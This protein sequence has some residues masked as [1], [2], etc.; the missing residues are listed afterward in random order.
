M[1]ANYKVDD[2]FGQIFHR[3]NIILLFNYKA[4][5]EVLIVAGFNVNDGYGKKNLVGFWK[6]KQLKN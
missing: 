5:N 6:I 3:D 1:K 4:I 2:S